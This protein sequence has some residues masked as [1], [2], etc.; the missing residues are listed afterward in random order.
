MAKNTESH[1]TDQTAAPK[2]KRK[3][4]LA[5]RANTKQALLINLLK[6]KKGATIVPLE[7]KGSSTPKSTFEVKLVRFPVSRN[8]F[9]RVAV[10]GRR[11][12]SRGPAI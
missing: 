9:M 2:S 11:R 12:P 4:P 5:V 3:P 7:L 10:P 6:R 1:T 8:P